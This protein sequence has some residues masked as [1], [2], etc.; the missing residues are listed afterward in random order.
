M[1][2]GVTAPSSPAAPS[3]RPSPGPTRHG[4]TDV[5]GRRPIRGRRRREGERRRGRGQPPAPARTGKRKRERGRGAAEARVARP[6]LR[7]PFRPRALPSSGLRARAPPAR[8]RARRILPLNALTVKRPVPVGP[9]RANLCSCARARPPAL[10][11]PAGRV[12]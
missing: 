9:S 2:D 4:N 11:L 5:R 6:A 12:T 1:T 10:R 8:G 3:R 7:P